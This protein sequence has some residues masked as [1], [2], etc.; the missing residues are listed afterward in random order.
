MFQKLER[1][2]SQFV[3]FAF[4]LADGEQSDPRPPGAKDA[5]EVDRAH[6][7]ELL[8]IFRFAIDVG[9]HVK[10]NSRR[11]Q[12]RGH[13]GRQSRTIHTWQSAEDH[14]R[15]S[16]RRPGVAGGDKSRGVSLAHQTQPYPHGGVALGAHGF[17]RLVIHA[18]HFA[19]MNNFQRQSGSRGMTFQFRPDLRLP[20]HQQHASTIVPGGLDGAFDLRLGGPIG[21]HRVE[22]YDAWHG[23]RWWLAGFFDVQYFA[24]LVIAAL[25]AGAMWHFLFVTV[26]TLRQ[27]VPLKRV[28]RPAIAG[29]R[30]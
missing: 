17:C 26:R 8:K 2:A 9:A 23:G 7:C 21:T 18:N 24:A 12:R 29:A 4:L 5:A 13:H 27:R 28:V 22:G 16:H 15:R 25:R 14:L 30:F 1:L 10:K 20:A 6:D 3:A 11:A 19:G